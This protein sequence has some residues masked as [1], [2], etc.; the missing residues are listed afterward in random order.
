MSWFTLQEEKLQ[1][2][3]RNSWHNP[4]GNNKICAYQIN[5]LIFSFFASIVLV[6]VTKNNRLTLEWPLFSSNSFWQDKKPLEII[7]PDPFYWSL[8]KV[9]LILFL[10][11]LNRFQGCPL[12][13]LHPWRTCLKTK[14]R[15]TYFTTN[16]KSASCQDKKLNKKP[17]R[18]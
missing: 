1:I 9:D 8:S 12:G 16:I 15:P 4:F 14:P 7:C 11:H 18:C 5:V 10:A 2:Y 17:L 3:W 13:V 6:Q